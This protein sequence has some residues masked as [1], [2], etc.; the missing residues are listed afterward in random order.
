MSPPPNTDDTPAVVTP[1][2]VPGLSV[3]A[4]LDAIKAR[5]K[6]ARGE[7]PIAKPAEKKPDPPAATA[8]PSD[9]PKP[10]PKPDDQNTDSDLKIPPKALKELG[11]LQGRVRELEPKVKEIESLQP[12]ANLAREVKKLWAGSFED[13]IKAIGIL[14]GKDGLD[15][16]VEMIKG[17]YNLE[18]NADPNTPSPEIK[19]LTDLIEAQNKKIEAL[20]AGNKTKDENASKARAEEE[21]KRGD[22]Y[23]KGFIDKNKSQ[24]ELCSRPEN[25]AEATDLAQEAAIK[26]IESDIAGYDEMDEKQKT[27]AFAAAFKQLTPET[28]EALYM[29]ALGEVEREYENIGK[30][31]SK[32]TDPKPVFDPARYDRFSR[33]LGKPQIVVK[34]EPLSKNPDE[35]YRQIVER[36]RA[37]AEAGGYR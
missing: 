26:M 35:R 19:K 15:E 1:P 9:Q 22:A 20:E 31:F 7:A 24:F 21:K 28:A 12:D 16:M 17:H 36:A 5:V 10:E 25:V 34:Y 37:K 18:Q 32:K 14:S 30:R 23:V 6:A 8:K 3:D 27:A 13:K 2:V 4:R 29:R 33:P 11:R